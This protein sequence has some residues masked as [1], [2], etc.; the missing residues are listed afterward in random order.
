MFMCKY[1]YAADTHVGIEGNNN[2]NTSKYTCKYTK[3]IDK[4]KLCGMVKL[5]YAFVAIPRQYIICETS[6]HR[7]TYCK[8]AMKS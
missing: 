5:S 6:R 8:R 3:T 2:H 7:Q 1:L 4:H